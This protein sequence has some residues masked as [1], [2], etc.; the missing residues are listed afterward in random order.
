MRSL[1]PLQERII[2]WQKR[3]TNTKGDMVEQLKKQI[4]DGSYEVSAE[5]FASHLLKAYEKRT[6]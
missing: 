1:F 2:R 6:I 5:D 4:S 3:E